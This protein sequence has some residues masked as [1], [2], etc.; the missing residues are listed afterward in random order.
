MTALILGL[1]ILEVSPAV[2]DRAVVDELEVARLEHHLQ[3][4]V[5]MVRDGHAGTERGF[6]FRADD[7]VAVL[8]QLDVVERVS[9]GG[10]GGDQRCLA[11]LLPSERPLRV[12]VA[13][14]E[15]LDLGF[16]NWASPRRATLG[17]PRASGEG[18]ALERARDALGL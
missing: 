1:T 17:F 18:P 3:H 12:I 7:R 13:D 11:R 4:N 2:Q 16:A 5:G 8:E 9:G 6:L 10:E 15:A 14:V